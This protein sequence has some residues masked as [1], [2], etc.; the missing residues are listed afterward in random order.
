MSLSAKKSRNSGWD[1]DST[2][3]FK[4]VEARNRA[5]E[6]Y[7]NTIRNN[8]II[9]ATGPAGTG[10]TYISTGY[11]AEQIYYKNIDRL[12]LTRPNVEAGDSM[13]F[14]PGDLSEKYL[15]Y[16]FPFLETLEEKLGKSHV[17]N[18][19]KNRVIEPIPIGFLRGRTFN[20]AIVILD[21]AQNATKEQFQLLLSRIGTEC[22]I[23][24]QGDI[25][26]VDISS[27]G[28]EDASKR[29]QRIPRVGMVSFQKSD[30]VRSKM[31]QY[32]VEAYSKK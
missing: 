7:L 30:I 23:I 13:G 6:E 8:D 11:A 14:L 12:I 29:L 4:R 3:Y 5:Q 27:S 1:N 9:I 25:D 18:L 2:N 20:N 17:Q 16:L 10:K 24:I 15:P 22:K 32:I 21:E 19:L 31:C 26:Q 28:L